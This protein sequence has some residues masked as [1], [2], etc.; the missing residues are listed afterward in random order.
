MNKRCD[1]VMTRPSSS[2]WANKKNWSSWSTS[3]WRNKCFSFPSWSA[4]SSS[5]PC[6]ISN[7]YWQLSSICRN[8]IYVYIYIYIEELWWPMTICQG[9]SVNISD[10]FIVD[11]SVHRTIVMISRE[12]LSSTI[13]TDSIWDS[14]L[15]VIV[16]DVDH[17]WYIRCKHSLD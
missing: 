2:M 11:E 1:Q 16:V 12:R 10:L 5:P 4:R 17:Y 8:C 15:V 14:C 6:S 3:L 13:Q 9:S 7:S